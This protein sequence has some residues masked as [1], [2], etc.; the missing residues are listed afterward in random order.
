MHSTSCS[1][2][3]ATSLL[4]SNLFVAT[5]SSKP[6]RT[7]F[8]CWGHADSPSCFWRLRNYGAL[9]VAD[10]R[11][12]RMFNGDEVLQ[13]VNQVSALVCLGCTCKLACLAKG[14]SCACASAC[15]EKCKTC[16]TNGDITLLPLMPPELMVS[17]VHRKALRERKDKFCSAA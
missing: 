7:V 5:T 9:Q 4:P 12:A 14:K 3:G 2:L 8:L 17:T 13:K 6:R 15:H 11:I 10:S 1:G 16:F